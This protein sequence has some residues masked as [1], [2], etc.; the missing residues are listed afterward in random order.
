MHWAARRGDLQMVLVLI[1]NG[2]DP[3]L[4]ETRF[5]RTPLHEAGMHGHSH[6]LHEMVKRG[7]DA[8]LKDTFG[9]RPST[10]KPQPIRP[11]HLVSRHHEEL[12]PST[13]HGC[14][15]LASRA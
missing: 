1:D 5:G 10:P 11:V 13:H 14:S 2:G 9:T 3:N 6:V 15:L 12:L 4:R 8:T 7:A